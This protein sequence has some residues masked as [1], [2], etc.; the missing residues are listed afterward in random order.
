MTDSHD[1]PACWMICY[2]ALSAALLLLLLL[3]HP[4][5]V[6]FCHCVILVRFCTTLFFLFFSSFISLSFS[7]ALLQRLNE[8]LRAAGRNER[9]VGEEWRGGGDEKKTKTAI[10]VT[11]DERYLMRTQ[12]EG[13]MTSSH[14]SAL[15]FHLFLL[16]RDTFRK[17]RPLLLREGVGRRGTN[18]NNNVGWKH[19]KKY[20]FIYISGEKETFCSKKKYF[21]QER[22]G[23]LQT[24]HN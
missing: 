20:I 21:L 18:G 22:R 23:L 15:I 24:C 14:R 2:S 19:S 5:R 11:E 1:C 16:F 13:E 8:R 3:L 9:E 4:I 7:S 17:L 10:R 12:R 6:S